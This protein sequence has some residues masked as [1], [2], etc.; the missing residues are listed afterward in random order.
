MH[1]CTHNNVRACALQVRREHGRQL[2][3]E[4]PVPKVGPNDP[5]VVVVPV[6]DSAAHAT[7]GT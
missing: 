5:P 7:M 2:A 1:A 6:P 3:R 4:H